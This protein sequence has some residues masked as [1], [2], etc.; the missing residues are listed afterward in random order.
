M[1]KGK[2]LLGRASRFVRKCKA[3]KPEDRLLAKDTPE[4]RQI[5]GDVAM[6]SPSGIQFSI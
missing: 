1:I 6:F 2:I 5:D 3:M 4:F